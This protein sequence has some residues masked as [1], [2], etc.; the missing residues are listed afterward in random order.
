MSFGTNIRNLRIKNKLTQKELADK[1]NLSRPTIGRYET[2]ERFPDKDVIIK[3]ADIFNISLDTLF[4]RNFKDKLIQEEEII[5]QH[6]LINKIIKKYN[7]PKE[8]LKDED[9]IKDIA[10]FGV[11]AALRIKNLR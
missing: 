8:Y 11:K 5:Y 7:I 6:D 9:F 2:D 1:L 10:D 3:L 4:D